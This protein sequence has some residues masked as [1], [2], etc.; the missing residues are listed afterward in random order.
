MNFHTSACLTFK[1]TK[2]TVW[3]TSD[4]KVPREHRS[5]FSKALLLKRS[6]GILMSYT[7]PSAQRCRY[8]NHWYPPGFKNGN[9][10]LKIY[11]YFYFILFEWR[12]TIHELTILFWITKNKSNPYFC[13]ISVHTTTGVLLYL[14]KTSIS[15]HRLCARGSVRA[16][17]M[18]RSRELVRELNKHRTVCA[19]ACRDSRHFI[20]KNPNRTEGESDLLSV[21]IRT[22]DIRRKWSSARNF[23]YRIQG[24]VSTSRG[25]LRNLIRFYMD[26][27]I[28]CYLLG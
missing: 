28:I 27:I 2:K 7:D 6:R 4:T 18:L 24:N 16:H 14:R 21:K 10:L 9:S 20:L 22:E 3:K 23:V 12:D 15:L 11:I 26:K 13:F 25:F 19:R 17:Q 8:H 5:V 1:F